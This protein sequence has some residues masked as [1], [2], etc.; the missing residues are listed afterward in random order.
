M[1]L[2]WRREPVPAEVKAALE[3]VPGER[4][5]SVCRSG[6]TQY[7]VASDRALYV[8]APPTAVRWR[9]DLI[10]Q[11]RWDPPSLHIDVRDDADS[12]PVAHTLDA[13]P[14]GD[15]PGVVRDR[16]TN[17]IIVN[18]AVAVGS[19]TVRV[20][21]RRN[22]DAGTFEWRLVPSA[23]VR[24]DD[25]AVAGVVDTELRRLRAQFEA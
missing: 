12:P 4:V 24:L 17:S 10:D 18:S 9:W 6:D 3:M 21:A 13:D 16:V 23:G 11:A 2:P 1:R 22:S 19:G 5:L 15:L 25:P 20:V 14:T 7:L 8:V